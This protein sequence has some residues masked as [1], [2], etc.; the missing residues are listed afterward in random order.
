MIS[1]LHMDPAASGPR[2]C[3]IEYYS[4]LLNHVSKIGKSCHGENISIII[5]IEKAKLRVYFKNFPFFDT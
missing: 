2:L 3:D 5:K 1:A 4:E